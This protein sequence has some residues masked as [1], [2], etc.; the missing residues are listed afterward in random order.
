[1]SSLHDDNKE[2]RKRKRNEHQRAVEAGIVTKT[3]KKLPSGYTCKICGVSDDHAVYE[4]PEG[5]GKGKSNDKDKDRDRDNKKQKVTSSSNKEYTP[6]P[7]NTNTNTN[8]EVQVYLSG[9]PFDYTSGKLIT[10]LRENNISNGLKHPFG[11]HMVC[12]KDNPNKC[13]GIAF[14][15]YMNI[16][17][18]NICV[19][20]LNNYIF[21]VKSKS[22]SDNDNDDKTETENENYEQKKIL[23]AE[24]NTR[25]Q[26][27]EWKAP[28]GESKIKGIVFKNGTGTMGGNGS[29]EY[30]TNTNAIKRCYRCGSDKHEPKD[31]T[32]DRICYRCKS[33]TH[34]SSDCPL[35]KSN[36]NSNSNGNG[37]SNR[38]GSGS[39]SGS[40][41][42][43]KTETN[44]DTNVDKKDKKKNKDSASASS[45][46]GSGSVHPMREKKRSSTTTSSKGSSNNSSSS[47]NKGGATLGASRGTGIKGELN[48]NNN[49]SNTKVTFD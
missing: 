49:S 46:S 38:V 10:L 39:D 15:T 9:L 40:Y 19:N 13:K 32:N 33:T 20:K 34:I 4:C 31:C 17:D 7:T 11:I 3:K 24:I 8:G 22:K 43:T 45:G 6:T 30:N 36:N 27:T 37:N 28:S 41:T 25:Q 18:A 48:I 26:A 1:M 14:I 16:N 42:E 47:G 44:T 5:K 23:K 21:H 35:K 2:E 29:G 12:F